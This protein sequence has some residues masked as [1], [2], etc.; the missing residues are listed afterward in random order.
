MTGQLIHENALQVKVL[1]THEKWFGITYKE[2]MPKVQAAIA[3]MKA[4][5]VYPEHLWK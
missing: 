5:G 2:D 3:D 4:R 1:P